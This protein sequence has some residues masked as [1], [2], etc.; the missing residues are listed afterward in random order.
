MSLGSRGG[1]G[2][3]KR[4]RREEPAD[5]SSYTPTP[6]SS[7]EETES[8][9]LERAAIEVGAEVDAATSAGVRDE[10]GSMGEVPPVMG[11]AVEGESS[12][13]QELRE[14]LPPRSPSKV[15]FNLLLP[16]RL[17]CKKKLE[18]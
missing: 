16:H 3:G 18:K 9:S 1:I 14:K 13:A 10:E 11:A 8:D 7:S 6:S 2:G 5:D 15:R 12:R 17:F 4:P